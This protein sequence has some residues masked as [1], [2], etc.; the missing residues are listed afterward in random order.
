MGIFYY[1]YKKDFNK[2]SSLNLYKKVFVKYKT[3]NKI[4]L[5]RDIKLY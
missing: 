5:D 4:I 3:L 2:K 1:L